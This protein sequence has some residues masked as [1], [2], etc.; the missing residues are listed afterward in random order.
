[1]TPHPTSK[2][3]FTSDVHIDTG[4][5]G[6][7][8]PETNRSD[9]HNSAYKCWMAIC[10]YVADTEPD[11]FLVGGDLFANARPGPESQEMIADGLKAVPR[12][13]PVIVV[14]GNH[15][16]IGLP[17]RHRH[18]LRHYAELPNVTVY[19][20]PTLHVLPNGI[21]LVAVPWPRRPHLVSE[22]GL[23]AHAPDEVDDLVAAHTA[24]GVYDLAGR[25]D[26]TAP[27][28]L[29]G[30]ATIGDAVVGS[31]RRGSEIS[32]RAVFH[33][34]VLPL[35]VVDDAVWS[36]SL[37]GHI[38]KA[39]TMGE[40]SRYAGSPDRVDFSEED[41]KKGFVVLGVGSDGTVNVETV[42]TP[43]RRFKTVRIG[44]GLDL[45]PGADFED[46][47][48]AERGEIV[49]AVL[50]SGVEADETELRSAARAHGAYL[51]GVSRQP[52]TREL[53]AGQVAIGEETT[54]MDGLELWI[55]K[56]GLDETTAKRVREESA[57]HIA[58]IGAASPR[59]EQT[60]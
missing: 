4:R 17:A 36:A 13:V 23:G 5:W 19:D 55:S 22:L 20:E 10:R 31:A 54:M 45:D 47:F 41:E 14:P 35:E 58:Q 12:S 42:P 56:E 60:A 50:A 7:L 3:V 8:D 37:W 57:R 16:Y 28:V 1:M 24:H 52:V 2:L 38:H 48:P 15:E 26:P 44:D 46:S 34:P 51:V 6:R 39:Q 49:R 53:R 11:A 27:A 40:R 9:A 43:A 18:V 32:I 33:E 29:F 21:Q 25:L 30:H 59:T